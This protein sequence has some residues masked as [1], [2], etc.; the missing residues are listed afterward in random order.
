M[1]ARDPPRCGLATRPSHHES[2]SVRLLLV[3]H[4]QTPS[5]VRGL[6]D[7]GAPGPGLTR[8]GHRQAAAVP[9]ALDGIGVDGIAVSTLV[10]THLTAAPLLG[11]HGLDPIELDGLRE[12]ESGDLEMRSDRDSH[13]EYMRAALAWGEG[14][15]DR[16][17]PGGPDGHAFFA[18]YDAAVDAIAAQ[19]WETAVAFSHGAAIRVWAAGRAAGVDAERIRDTPLANTGL[20]EVEG[21]PRSGW[22][23]VRWS[24]G[25]LGGAHLER[26]D[27]D[28]PTG[29]S[30][31]ELAD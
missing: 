16:R 28:D 21:D 5:N 17:I 3:R 19:G 20:I 26:D 13:M 4:G 11:R 6:L 22:R 24:D 31:E 2:P 8:L 29:E 1:E 12:V 14:D 18:R 7:S 30:L 25:P 10:R 23:F 9:E 27:V 15:L